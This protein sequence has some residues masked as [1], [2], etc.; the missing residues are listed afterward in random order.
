Q[1][2]GGRAAAAAR[3][4]PAAPRPSC[5]EADAP[6]PPP[7]S[8]SPPPS[9]SPSPSRSAKPATSPAPSAPRAEPPSR[10]APAPRIEYGH[11]APKAAF[12]DPLAT[13][14]AWAAPL[15]AA[16][17]LA[18]RL[19]VGWHR[20]PPRYRGPAPSAPRVEPP[21]R[22]APAPRI[23]YG[24]LAPKEAFDDPLTTAAAWAAPLLAAAVLA[25]RLTVGWASLPPRYR[26]RRRSRRGE[27]AEQGGD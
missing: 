3:P 21:S 23:E 9:P 13:A 7:A 25:L 26:G 6:P 17:V 20:F 24:H 16:A 11:L 27:S 18:L 1:R 19:T 2:P 10:P 4:R 8:P 14:A 12:D 22:P 5:R 15:L